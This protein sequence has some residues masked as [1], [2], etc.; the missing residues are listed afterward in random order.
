MQ[1]AFR[2]PQDLIYVMSGHENPSLFAGTSDYYGRR[3]LPSEKNFF[4]T[5][6]L[7]G[8][9]KRISSPP[10]LDQP[11]TNPTLQM[12]RIRKNEWAVQFTHPLTPLQ[13]FGVCL[14][15]FE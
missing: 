4:V 9:P 2:L 15:R 7:G 1:I 8:D 11:P 12:N 5:Y 14:T 6:V 3:V 13:A 10:P